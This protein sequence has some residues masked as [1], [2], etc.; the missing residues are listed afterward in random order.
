MQT[1]HWVI[2]A[3]EY[4]ASGGQVLYYLDQYG[5]GN[6]SSQNFTGQGTV[7]ATGNL[8]EDHSRPN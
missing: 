4:V 6:V 8:I 1:N 7:Y 3:R 5:Y 2:A